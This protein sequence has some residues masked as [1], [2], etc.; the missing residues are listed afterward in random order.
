MARPLEISGAV[1]LPKVSR[2]RESALQ[3]AY[4]GCDNGCC[5]Q[6]SLQPPAVAGSEAGATSGA[7]TVD[8]IT[9]ISDI[10]SWSNLISAVYFLPGYRESNR[11]ISMSQSYR[12]S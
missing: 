11:R 4:A 2:G 12:G 5:D 9:W 1:V 7:A 3:R 8:A 6:L 10:L